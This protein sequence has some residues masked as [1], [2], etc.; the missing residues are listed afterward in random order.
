MDTQMQ[1]DI[2]ALTGAMGGQNAAAARS[3]ALR[4]AQNELD[5]RLL[6]QPVI[7]VDPPS[8]AARGGSR[9]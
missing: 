1:A 7:D 6:Y 5:L 4:I 3:A 2:D 8:S 9:Q